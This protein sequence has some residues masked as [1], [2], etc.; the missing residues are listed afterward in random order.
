MKIPLDQ[1]HL[2]RPMKYTSKGVGEIGQLTEE[3][4]KEASVAHEGADVP[5]S[6]GSVRIMATQIP[7]RPRG[8]IIAECLVI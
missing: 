4:L 8:L 7:A 5:N 1:A 3:A 6:D 2:Y